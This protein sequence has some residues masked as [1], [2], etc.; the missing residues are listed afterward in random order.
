MLNQILPLVKRPIRYTGGEFNLTIKSCPQNYVGIVFP[1]V[2]EIGMSN[3]GIK[4]IYHIFNQSPNIQCERIFAPWPDFGEKLKENN[5]PLYG[6]ETKKPINE[7]DLLGFSLQSELNYTNVL[8]ILEIAQIPYKATDRD[9]RHPILIAGGPCTLNPT[10]MSPVFDAFVIG[11]GED[12]V[13]EIAGIITNIP[14]VKKLQRLEEIAK[15]EG[16]WVP[17][18][19]KKEKTIKKRAVKELSEDTIPSPAILPICEVTHDRLALEVMRGCTYGCRFCQAGYVNRPLRIRPES[20]ILKSIDKGIRETGWEEVSLLSFSILDYPGLSGLIRKLN[21]LL[22]KKNVSV[23][24][25][26]MR[27]ELFTEEMAFLLK[28]IKKTG[29]TFAPE[30]GSGRLRKKINKQFSEEN[31]ARAI[32]IAYEQGW[33]QVKL[34]FMVGLPFEQ[35]EDVEEIKRLVDEVLRLYPK[36]AIK[37]SLSA[38]VP[39]PH[40]PFESMPFLSIEELYHRIGIVRKIK[41]NRVDLRYQAPEVSF[42]EALLSRAD[43]KIFEVIE[44]VYRNG[45]R[46]EEWREYFD[47]GR[48]QKAFEKTGINPWDYLGA[49]NSS[50]PWDFIDIGLK[51]DFLKSEY[52]KAEKGESTPNCYYESCSNCGACNGNMPKFKSS[53]ETY[54]NYG[55][56]PKRITK[57]IVYRIKYSIG[58]EFRYASHLDVTRAIY[59]ALRRTDLP[60]S[61]T[62]GFSP[63]PRVSF[64]PPKSVGQIS[65]SDYFDFYLDGEYFGNI[66]RELN[67]RFPPS[68]RILDVRAIPSTTPSL[69]SSINLI[70]YEVPIP[71]NEIR[72]PIE[73]L[74]DQ[75][76]YI[77]SKGR[78]KNISESIE[79]ITFKENNLVCGLYYGEKYI[80]IYELLA[81]LT[82][83]SVE[84]AKKYMVT[85]TLMFIKKD[86]LLYSPM[87]VK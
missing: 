34:Y 81:Y 50:R 41:K 9:E 10:P 49:G 17:M 57:P 29:L 78:V 44:E 42:I 7:F 35:D 23:S 12:V 45:A 77:S 66:S 1:E 87:E 38:F 83:L 21:N 61:Y 39:K 37:L 40:T 15:I 3:L 75:P 62:S 47:F 76:V 48:W 52:E 72:K 26:A 60:L 56:Y 46:F 80:N 8:Y 28:E 22:K 16:V 51:K 20:V 63:I 84:Q 54:L 59:R 27:G 67:S 53:E 74:K 85:R 71:E 30:S 33:R 24:L 65:K 25:P 69:S 14:K 19:H 64:G 43:E 2:Y 32:R 86:G 6:L 55:R 82:E 18:I 5:I 58:E 36:G 31:L 4:V 70:Y 11:D 68:I 13:R 73:T 79:S